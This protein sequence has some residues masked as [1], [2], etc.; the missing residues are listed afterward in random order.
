MLI[1]NNS[2]IQYS[3]Y[4][5]LLG[6]AVGDAYG[7]TYEGIKPKRLAK[8]FRQNNHYHLIPLIHGGMVSDDTEHAVMTVQAFISS[9]GDVETFKKSLKWRLVLWLL[10]LP[11]GI[12]MATGRAIFKIML[13]FSTTG[14]YSAGNGVA[15]RASVLGVLCA[16]LDE[17]KAFIHASSVITHTDPKA[18]QGALAVALLAW[19]ECYHPD[20]TVAQSRAF[21]AEH[22]NDSELLTLI[23]SY[24]A[25]DKGVLG[26][27]YAT[28]PA[29]IQTWQQYR[30]DP[31]Q[32]LNHL[33]ALGGD[34]DTAGAIFG[35]IVG[36]RHGEAMFKQIS[37]TWC[38]PILT[39]QYFAKLANQIEQISPRHNFAQVWQYPITLLLKLLRNLLFLVIVLL[40]GFRRIFP[41]Y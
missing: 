37:G 14:V 3:L 29:V 27:I 11:A 8:L 24:Q 18:E 13:G 26:Y 22:L 1:T 38:E 7:L 2:P 10:A 21:L 16:D 5:S 30:D 39:P 6:G 19:I 12:G 33:I 25:D 4:G 20:W 23:A 36:V 35:G 28:V 9:G 34:T 15:M 40:H 32:G 17:L 41:P 31:V